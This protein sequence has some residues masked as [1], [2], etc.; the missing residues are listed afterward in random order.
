MTVSDGLSVGMVGASVKVRF[1]AN[2]VTVEE[3]TRIGDTG[4]RTA[5]VKL[6]ITGKALRELFKGDPAKAK[7]VL[8]IG[9]ILVRRSI[10]DAVTGMPATPIGTST[11]AARPV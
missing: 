9:G 3:F 8:D 1:P 4:S 6:S 5:E 11:P 2:G 7:V 10:T